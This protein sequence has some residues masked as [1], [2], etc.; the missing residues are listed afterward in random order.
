MS[1]SN[2][3]NFIEREL[4]LDSRLL[5]GRK[6]DDYLLKI[7]NNAEVISITIKGRVVGCAVYYCNDFESKTAYL[8]MLIVD[9]EYYGRGI[10]GW[11]LDAFIMKVKTLGFN[12]CKLEVRNDNDGAIHVYSK[13]GFT[14]MD[15]SAGN[16]IMSLRV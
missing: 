12:W 15:E 3:F 10:G 9:K 1:M 6:A 5:L 2:P 8:S 4:R 16:L 14:K 11:L 7:K 13:K